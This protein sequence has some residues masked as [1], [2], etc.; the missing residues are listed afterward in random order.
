MSKVIF[1]AFAEEDHLRNVV[2]PISLKVDRIVFFSRQGI[3]K[4]SVETPKNIFNK[5]LNCELEFISLGDN[6]NEKIKE[7]FNKYPNAIIDMS[8]SRYV[9][10]LLFEYAIKNGN[11]IYYFDEKENAIEHFPPKENCKHETIKF[12]I[13]EMIY[14]AGGSINKNIHTAPNLQDKNTINIICNT[15][16][17]M[18]DKYDSFTN[19]LTNIYKTIQ[20]NKITD[21]RYS[22]GKNAKEK[23]NKINLFHELEKHKCFEINNNTLK[24]PSNT[25]KNLFEVSGSW[26]ESYA[27]IKLKES[28]M[29][30]DVMMSAVI[31]FSKKK[32]TNYPVN[33]EIDLLAI[34]DNHLYMASCKSNKVDSTAINEIALHNAI[35]GNELSKAAIFT[36]DNV[37]ERSPAIYEKAKTLGVWVVEKPDFKR[38]E[39]AQTLLKSL[40]YS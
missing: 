16:E 6:E 13:E 27:Y 19:S 2:I 29:F 35:F 34:K 32:K 33:C 18:L 1:K 21:L 9:L 22:L 36:L 11:E 17:A 28:E 25:I 38:G 5:Y 14:L 12:S 23:L 39:I 31:D 26:L 37:K 3:D 20:D 7:A 30:D 8:G 10:L 24:F 40:K 15:F 4:E